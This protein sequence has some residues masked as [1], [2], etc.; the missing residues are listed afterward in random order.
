M[1]SSKKTPAKRFRVLNTDVMVGG[2]GHLVITSQSESSAIE[3]DKFVL[4]CVASLVGGLFGSLG[5][6]VA[7]MIGVF[8]DRLDHFGLLTW[9][10]LW[11]HWSW[12]CMPSAAF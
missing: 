3:L 7:V 6:L 12:Y 9:W 10:S 8:G 4:S 5:H 2:T 1:L 11:S